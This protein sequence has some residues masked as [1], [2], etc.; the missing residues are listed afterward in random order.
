[1]HGGGDDPAQA[2]GHGSGQDG[3]GYV[4]LLDDF[5]PDVERGQLHHDGEGDRKNQDAEDGEDEG[6]E[7]WRTSRAPGGM[8]T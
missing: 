6:V 1:M 7:D 2:Q 4:V 5:L 8:P 3:G